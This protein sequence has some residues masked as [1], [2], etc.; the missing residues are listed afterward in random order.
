MNISKITLKNTLLMVGV[1]AL[2][3]AC[4]QEELPEN[5]FSQN[6]VL[7]DLNYLAS[8]ELRGR[9]TGS[10]EEAIAAEYIANRFDQL[11]LQPA[12]EEGYFQSFTKKPHPTVQKMNDGDSTR[13]GMG[14]VKELT[15]KN[16]IAKLENGS[17]SWI[18][19]GAH[20][21]HLGMGD[22]NSLH[23]EGSAIHNGADDN[24]SGVA[25]MLSLAEHINDYVKKSNVLFIAFSGEEK[26]LWGSN[27]F[28]D[29]PTIE[30]SKVKYMINF[31]MVGRM[32]EENTLAIYGN[33]T[34]PVWNAELEK[35]NA[36]SLR[37]VLSESG[38]GPS[39]HTSFYLEDIPVLHLFT[40]QHEDYHKPSDDVEKI[41]LKGME[42][43]N[44]YTAR[45]IS[46]LDLVADM[47]FTKTKDEDNE[48]APAF[49]VTLGVIPDYLYD[50]EGMRIDGLREERPAQMAGMEKGDIVVAM[51]DLK[52]D[53]MQTYMEGL[54]KFEPKDTTQVKVVR[55]GDTLTVDV[56]WD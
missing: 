38:V 9:G 6:L 15:G 7:A 11:G 50:G 29:K 4:E 48:S 12:G 52:V 56:I 46:S 10:P 8:D 28:C 13:F 33:G 44:N 35:A 21:D 20:Y 43:V 19:I 55:A 47:P 3:T 23:M 18:V 32:N 40:G 25:L 22:E 42:L 30:M 5:K 39:D 17:D 53:G 36:D 41:N 14:V 31:D 26:G 1:F 54:S 51:G 16:V 49:K 27:T 34:S 45:L 24:A 2:F 37:L